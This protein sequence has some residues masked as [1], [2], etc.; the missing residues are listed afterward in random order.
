MLK[1][2]I[3]VKDTVS[4][5]FNDPRVEINAG[6]AIRAFSQSVQESVNKDDYV[7][8]QVGTFDTTNGKVKP[9]DPIRI[10]SGHDVKT[11]NVTSITPH[12]Q[13]DDLAKHEALK[14]QSGI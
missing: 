14:K 9:N 5:V 10:Y 3:S 4:E 2:I 13:L 7:M 1:I 12:Q 11:D 6:S 8:Y